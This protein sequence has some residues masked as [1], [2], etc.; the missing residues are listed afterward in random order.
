MHEPPRSSYLP[1]IELARQE[2]LG[3]GDISSELTIPVQQQGQGELAFRQ[4]GVLCGMVVVQEVLHLYHSSII[5]MDAGQEGTV[6]PAGGVVGAVRGPR[7]ALLAA[8]RVMLNFLQ[9]LS[10]I[11][12]V[13]AQ[14]VEAVASTKAKIYDTRYDPRLEAV[15]KNM[16]F[17]VAAAVLIA[18]GSSMLSSSKTIISRLWAQLIWSRVCNKLCTNCS[19]TPFVP[20]LC[21][22][23]SI[24]STSCDLF[25]RF[26]A[27]T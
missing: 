6:I 27:L 18:R 9:R 24:T 14:Y 4:N 11:A 21:K 12:T 8:E 2:D 1:L 7:R 3:P 17:V 13:T 15:G 26:G 19:R 20:T 22:S 25:C 10:A 23:K 16:R 5:L